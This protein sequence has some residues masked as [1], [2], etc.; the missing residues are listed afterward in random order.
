M[1]RHAEQELTISMDTLTAEVDGDKAQAA[2][3]QAMS[4]LDAEGAEMSVTA[5][6]VK[7]DLADVEVDSDTAAAQIEAALGMESGT[8]AANG[9]EVQAGA[10]VTIPSELVVLIYIKM[11]QKGLA[12]CIRQI[13]LNNLRICRIVL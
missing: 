10:S 7:V 1:I 9:I 11:K 6:G 2:I 3:E 12:I 5:E 8:L 4:A 13:L